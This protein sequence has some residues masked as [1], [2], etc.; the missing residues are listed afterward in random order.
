MVPKNRH[1]AITAPIPVAVAMPKDSPAQ[2]IFLTSNNHKFVQNTIVGNVAK[3]SS[4][5]SVIISPARA[6]FRPIAIEKATPSL[7]FPL[8]RHGFHAAS[9]FEGSESEA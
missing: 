6:S 8:K 7:V 4:T 2:H 9:H 5:A 3:N 1:S